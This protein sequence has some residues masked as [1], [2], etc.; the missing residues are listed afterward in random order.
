MKKCYKCKIDKPLDCFHNYKKSRDGKYFLCKE[1]KRV[2]REL[3]YKR[4]CGKY[5]EYRTKNREKILGR[6]RLK[7][8][9]LGIPQRIIIK[10]KNCKMCGVEFKPYS[11]LT[12][13]CSRS[14]FEKSMKTT[15]LGSNNPAYRNGNSTKEKLKNG[16]RLYTNGHL[17]ACA[18]YKREFMEKHGY[19]HCECCGTSNAIRFET[20]H[21][22]FASEAP[23]HENLHN[24]RNMICVC[25]MCHNNF[26]AHKAIRGNL[27]RERK[28]WELFP[29]I[30]SL[31]NIP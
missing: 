16:Q 11:S 2:E 6:Q 15:R 17:R 27:I 25:I 4:N 30:L 31:K 20:H 24:S 12:K 29:E 14:C 28:L 22:V 8:L 7:R 18:R 5:I 19:M 3:E 23:K 1:C 21:I 26:H 13:F 10:P 9:E